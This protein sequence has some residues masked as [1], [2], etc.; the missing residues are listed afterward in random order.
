MNLI[1]LSDLM[2]VLN[3]KMKHY[4]K[5]EL[6]QGV[7]CCQVYTL[8]RLTTDSNLRDTLGYG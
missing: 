7:S 5:N 4:T 6:L 3:I 2:Q 1:M 8:T